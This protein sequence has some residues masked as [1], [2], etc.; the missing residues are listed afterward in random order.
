[1]ISNSIRS[2]EMREITRLNIQ[3]PTQQ[4][5]D[6]AR[7]ARETGFRIMKRT[8]LATAI[9][10][11]SV[12]AGLSIKAIASQGLP[13]GVGGK[14]WLGA[15]CFLCTVTAVGGILDLYHAEPKFQE[16]K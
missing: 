15:G 2:V 7:K 8:S 3:T 11:T 1:M 13:E 4:E 9:A 10:T 6:D 5:L 12:L 16:K 14:A